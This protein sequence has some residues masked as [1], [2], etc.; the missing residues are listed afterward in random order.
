MLHTTFLT[1]P[2]FCFSTIIVP[3]CPILKN[4]SLSHRQINSPMVNRVTETSQLSSLFYS[5]QQRLIICHIDNLPSTDIVIG[6]P[7][8]SIFLPAY[9]PA[10]PLRVHRLWQGQKKLIWAFL[11]QLPVG[12]FI[13]QS[14]LDLFPDLLAV[15]HRGQCMSYHQFCMAGGVAVIHRRCHI[16]NR[17]NVHRLLLLGITL[18]SLYCQINFSL[19]GSL[20]RPMSG[21]FQ[22]HL[23]RRPVCICRRCRQA[24]QDH[25]CRHA[26]RGYLS[27]YDFPHIFCFLLHFADNKLPPAYRHRHPS[28]GMASW[29]LFVLRKK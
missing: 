2:P 7:V 17:N 18:H 21:L 14:L 20:I 29:H 26:C 16:Q 22:N 28:L 3:G 15:L 24:L 8:T 1:L 23:L 5:R 27:F 4:F 19:I 6:K 13:R 11:S 25:E 10:F 12:F 9:Q